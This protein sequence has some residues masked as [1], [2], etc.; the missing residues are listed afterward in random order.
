MSLLIKSLRYSVGINF[1]RVLKRNYTSAYARDTANKK[2]YQREK[3]IVFFKVNG[4]V[5]CVSFNGEQILIREWGKDSM[6]VS[7]EYSRLGAN[8]DAYNV[9]GYGYQ[10][11][12]PEGN[13][14]SYGQF[15]GYP[16]MGISICTI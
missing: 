12:V 11:W 6:D 13:H 4:K 1:I 16:S 3:Y 7:A 10:W 9:I 2:N 15:L 8:Q 14:D 5:I